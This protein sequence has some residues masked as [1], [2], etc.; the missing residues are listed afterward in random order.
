MDWI[1]SQQ[2]L[3]C[4]S[5][6]KRACLSIL[7]TWQWIL[8]VNFTS[9]SGAC[10]HLSGTRGLLH[11]QHSKVCYQKAWSQNSYHFSAV[12]SEIFLVQNSAGSWLESS[13]FSTQKWLPKVNKITICFKTHLNGKWINTTDLSP[14][15]VL[16]S[17]GA[18]SP[19]P[20]H[21]APPPQCPPAQ[22]TNAFYCKLHRK[23]LNKT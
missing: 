22:H 21:I 7:I 18:T 5:P 11:H 19:A 16:L 1:A 4:P 10:V 15:F 2:C 9:S 12:I 13:Q 14:T 23:M 3:P 20:A 17:P 6:G 8:T